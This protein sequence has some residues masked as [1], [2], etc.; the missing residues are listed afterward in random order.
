V[1][2]LVRDVR[3]VALSEFAFEKNLGI[4]RAGFDEYLNDMLLGRKRYSS[5]QDHT[6]SYLDSPPAKAGNFLLIRYEDL[7]QNSVEM[8][9]KLVDFLGVK[10]DPRAV[11]KALADN[12]IEK[13]RE[14]EDRLYSQEDYE[15]VP[16]RPEKGVEPGG[17]F[18]RSGKMGSWQETLTPDQLR[19]IEKH[20][21]HVLRRLH[22]PV[23]TLDPAETVS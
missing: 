16:R 7:R 2:H 18:V 14:K 6:Q 8:F 13:M 15:D 21:A 11:E 20:T 22:Y 10:V 12:S 17:R 4:R 23:V 9:T 5:W 1:V 3:D 19:L